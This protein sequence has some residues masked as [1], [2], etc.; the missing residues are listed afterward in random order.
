MQGGR[1]RAE[2]T[3]RGRP[4]P[5]GRG[6]GRKRPGQ[7]SEACR[8]PRPVPSARSIPPPT[9][10][11]FGRTP[12]FSGGPNPPAF[13][14]RPRRGACPGP[15]RRPGPWRPQA[16]NAGGLGPERLR[17]SAVRAFRA[18]SVQKCP[19]S[20]ILASTPIVSRL[21]RRIKKPLCANCS[22]YAGLYL[23]FI[24][25]GRKTSLCF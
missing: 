16:A 13:G 17:V 15:G 7:A 14:R 19:S 2:G 6:P 23:Y 9:H 11:Y 20:S 25:G 4:R 18:L 8:R 1:G 22:F 21:F 24:A 10:P 3:G 5:L 12:V